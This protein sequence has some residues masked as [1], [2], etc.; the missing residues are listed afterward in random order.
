[1]LSVYFIKDLNLCKFTRLRYITIL[2]LLV[3]NPLH[4]QMQNT[5]KIDSA[6]SSQHN[7]CKCKKVKQLITSKSVHSTVNKGGDLGPEDEEEYEGGAELGAQEAQEVF[8]IWSRIRQDQQAEILS[9]SR[10]WVK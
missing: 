7:Y 10:M 6:C 1:M 2:N 5:R 4:F 9:P 3:L 8:D